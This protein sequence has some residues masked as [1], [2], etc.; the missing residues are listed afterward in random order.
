MGVCLSLYLLP[1]TCA[2]NAVPPS[3]LQPLS[4]ELL[5]LAILWC[6]DADMVVSCVSHRRWWGWRRRRVMFC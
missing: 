4:L 2:Q 3:L 1:G 6:R 5:T